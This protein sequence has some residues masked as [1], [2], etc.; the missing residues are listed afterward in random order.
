M[1]SNFFLLLIFLIPVTFFAQTINNNNSYQVEA[2]DQMGRPFTAPGVRKAE[3][4]PLLNDEWGKGQ[5]KFKRGPVLSNVDLQFNL[6]NNELYFRKE[7]FTFIFVDTVTEFKILYKAKD[8]NQF[9]I[10]RNHYPDGRNTSRLTYF[11]VL[12]EGNK[13]HLLKHIYKTI[14]E[15]YR[16]GEQPKKE[17]ELKEVLYVYT[18]GNQML[19][20]IKPGLNQLT[21][22]L[23]DFAKEIKQIAHAKKLNPDDEAGLILLINELNK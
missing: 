2:Y 23:P 5:V 6:E 13:V 7:G 12:A 22:A 15:K 11:E 9:A 4:S 16:Y 1:K 17:Y 14:Q 3:G 19:V 8:T 20:K 10:F 21:S 18:P